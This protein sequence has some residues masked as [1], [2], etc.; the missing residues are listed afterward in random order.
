MGNSKLTIIYIY[1]PLCGWCYGFSGVMKSLYEKHQQEF[2]FEVISGGMIL[3]DRKGSITGI[4]DL[5]RSH[6]PHLVET[7]GAKFGEPFLKALS[8]GGIYMSSEKPCIALSVF[9]SYRPQEAVLF[10]RDLQKL[11]YQE[12]KDLTLDETYPSLAKAYKIDPQ[13]FMEKLNTEEYKQAAYY[14][15]ALARQLQVT[16]FPAAFIRTGE[17]HFYKITKGYADLETMELRISNVWK[18]VMA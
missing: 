1:D 18:E 17:H 11:L 10:V 9:K 12:G 4:S 6:Y 14:D 2:D 15:F 3:G 16:G 8:E 7:T 5:I 13:E